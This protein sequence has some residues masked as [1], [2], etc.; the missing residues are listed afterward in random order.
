MKLLIV[1]FFSL[2]FIFATTVE[3]P[4]K[5]HLEP[6][7]VKNFQKYWEKRGERRFNE[8]YNK[9]LPYLQYLHSQKW[10]KNFFVNAPKFKK[11]LVKKIHSC[12]Q[13]VCILGILLFKDSSPIYLYDKWI[14][15]NGKWYHRYN[16][17]PLP[18]VQ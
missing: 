3:I 1:L 11:V 16:D 17:S 13:N 4:H 5:I 12:T 9:E 8:I 18:V 14:K 15:V 2:S 6:S 10:Y 7:L